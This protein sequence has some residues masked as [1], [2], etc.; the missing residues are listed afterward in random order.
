MDERT[1]DPREYRGGV[2]EPENAK[3]G[4]DNEGVVPREMLDDGDLPPQEG[5]DEQTLKDE[6]MGDVTGED[7]DDVQVD[8]TAGDEADA[9]T[10]DNS[11]ETE[12]V[13]T[14]PA[15]VAPDTGQGVA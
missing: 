10:Q 1:E 2:R 15:T 12:T 11:R 7:S 8:R 9:T 14:D 4:A 6:V 3:A 13:H 5:A